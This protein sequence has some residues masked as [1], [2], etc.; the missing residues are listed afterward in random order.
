[1]KTW[2]TA[3]ALLTAACGGDPDIERVGYFSEN[4][5]QIRTYSFGA[6]VTDEQIRAF[7][8]AEVSNPDRLTASYFY[9]EGSTIPADGLTMAGNLIDATD[10][11]YDAPGLSR[12]RYAYM[13]PLIGEVQF[14]DCV[15]TP[16]DGLCRK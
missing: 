3:L 14:I 15:V 13:R 10:L 12:W 6:R 5:H 2:V 4:G 9:P 1:M 8:E 11:I 16:M 7:A